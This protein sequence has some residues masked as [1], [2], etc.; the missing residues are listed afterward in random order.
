MAG[1]GS[2]VVVFVC[3]DINLTHGVFFVCFVRV[4]SKKP[5]GGLLFCY[6]AYE[7]LT[8]VLTPPPIV[9]KAEG[10]HVVLIPT[11]QN[12]NVMIFLPC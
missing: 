4:S 7:A 6:A 12:A 3:R 5:G 2:C 1:I 9:L 10:A 11:V 8:F